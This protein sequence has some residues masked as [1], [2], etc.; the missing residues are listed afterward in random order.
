MKRLLSFL[1]GVL[2]LVATATLLFLV[3]DNPS[4]TTYKEQLRD[5]NW[6]MPAV[7]SVVGLLMFIAIMMLI[8][9]L[10]PSHKKRQLALKYGEGDLL[11]NKRAIEKNIRYTIAKYED[12]RQPSV[13]VQM[14]DKKKTSYIDIVID[15]FIA[16]TTNVQTLMKTMRNE[17]KDTTEHFS[18]LPVRDVKINVLDQKLLNKRVM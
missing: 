2:L 8:F 4:W 18:Q 12:I 9:A 13:S 16:Q 3:I 14:Y 10:S 11:L 17:V 1:Y 6:F 5:V 15:V 7:Y